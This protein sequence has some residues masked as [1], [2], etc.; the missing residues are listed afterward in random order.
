[1]LLFTLIFSMII[2][3]AGLSVIFGVSF[4]Q[5]RN[6]KSLQNSNKD[7]FEPSYKSLFAPSDEEIRAFEREAET[8]ARMEKSESE[9]KIRLLESE[10]L[11]EI[12][13]VWTV[14][15][16][17]N[18]SIELLF[19]AAQSKSAETFSKTARSVIRVWQQGSLTNL[20]AVELA[21][22]IESHIWLLPQK[23][24]TSGINFWLKQE[25]A[26]LRRK[27]EESK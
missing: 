18:N 1:M 12:Q 27:S 19:L 8:K 4:F 22:L 20:K 25:L 2:I 5:K 26:E 15:P 16:N 24:R 17:K 3:T 7:N 9:Q 23:E 11:N 21:Q 13:K 6:I 14:N 10:R